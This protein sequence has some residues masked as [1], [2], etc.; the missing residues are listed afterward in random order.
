MTVMA[1]DRSLEVTTKS[2][3]TV[4]IYAIGYPQKLQYYETTI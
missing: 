4:N 2:G 3:F 1:G